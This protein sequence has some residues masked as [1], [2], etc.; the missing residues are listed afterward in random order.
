M[1]FKDHHLSKIFQFCDKD[2]YL[3]YALV[4]KQ[5]YNAYKRH[6]EGKC[7]TAIDSLATSSRCEYA[8]T[9]LSLCP[10]YHKK[11]SSLLTSIA[12][13]PFQRKSLFKFLELGFSVDTEVIKSVLIHEDNVELI[14]SLIVRGKLRLHNF[15]SSVCSTAA[16]FGRIHSLI[17][18]HSRRLPWDSMTTI[19][20]AK[21]GHF[22]CLRFAALAGC[23]LHSR[24]VEYAALNGHMFTINWLREVGCPATG[25]A[26][27]AAVQSG[28]ASIVRAVLL[29]GGPVHWD[30][31]KAAAA[32]GRIDMLILLRSSEYPWEALTISAAILSGHIET[33]K[34]LVNEGCPQGSNCMVAAASVGN[35]EMCKWLRSQGCPWDEEAMT[36]AAGGGHLHVVDWLC[37]ETAPVSSSAIIEAS[38][39]AHFTIAQKLI[40]HGVNMDGAAA[41]EAAVYSG[42]ERMVDIIIKTLPAEEDPVEEH[43]A[44][45]IT[46]VPPSQSAP[47]MQVVPVVSL[48]HDQQQQQQQ[49]QQNQPFTQSLKISQNNGILHTAANVSSR[50][51]SGCNQNE[52][53]V[54]G[55]VDLVERVKLKLSL[56]SSCSSKWETTNRENDH[57]NESHNQISSCM[58]GAD[59]PIMSNSAE[60]QST[61]NASYNN[62]TNGVLHLPVPPLSAS[63]R[64]IADKSRRSN[65]AV[66]MNSSDN[67]ACLNNK[68]GDEATKRDQNLQASNINHNSSSGRV[69][70]RITSTSSS[71]LLPANTLTSSQNQAASSLIKKANHH[72]NQQQSQ[73]ESQREIISDTYQ[74]SAHTSNNNLSRLLSATSSSVSN[75]SIENNGN[76]NHKTAS[77]GESFSSTIDDHHIEVAV[78]STSSMS[79]SEIDH[80]SSSFST[81][82]TTT[83]F[84][85]S[86]SYTPSLACTAALSDSTL[87]RKLSASHQIPLDATVMAALASRGLTDDFKWAASNSGIID[88]LSLIAAARTDQLHILKMI[89]QD[90]TFGNPLAATAEK[91]FVTQKNT[92]LPL[93]HRPEATY[94]LVAA[95]CGN[96]IATLR[97]L[98][99]IGC[100]LSP[101]VAAAAAQ[102]GDLGILKWLRDPQQMYFA[103]SGLVAELPIKA[104]IS[105]DLKP[106]VT[107]RGQNCS[108]EGL[109]GERSPVIPIAV[110]PLEFMTS[111]KRKYEGFC[112]DTSSFDKCAAV[113][114]LSN[115][116]EAPFDHTLDSQACSSSLYQTRHYRKNLKQMNIHDSVGTTVAGSV[117]L[118]DSSM[119]SSTHLLNGSISMS[120][121]VPIRQSI[122]ELD[123]QK[124]ITTNKDDNELFE[125]SPL[126]PTN[127]PDS[128]TPTASQFNSQFGNFSSLSSNN[129]LM[130]KLPPFPQMMMPS[131]NINHF[132]ISSPI[133]TTVVRNSEQDEHQQFPNKTLSS[134]IEHTQDVNQNSPMRHDK[135][136]FSSQT[137]KVSSSFSGTHSPI[138]QGSPIRQRRRSALLQTLQT[139]EE[140]SSPSDTT[141]LKYNEDGDQFS[142]ILNRFQKQQQKIIFAPS[143]SFQIAQNKTCVVGSPAQ[144]NCIPRVLRL[145]PLVL[146]GTSPDSC[147]NTTL[148]TAGK[149]TLTSSKTIFPYG[150]IQLPFPLH[151]VCPWDTRTAVSFV[152][153]GQISALLWL[154]N[155]NCPVDANLVRSAASKIGN[156]DIARRICATLGWSFRAEDGSVAHKLQ[157]DAFVSFLLQSGQVALDDMQNSIEAMEK[158]FEEQHMNN[159]QTG[160]NTL[161]SSYEGTDLFND[162]ADVDDEMGQDE[163]EFESSHHH[164][165]HL[166]VGNEWSLNSEDESQPIDERCSQ[167][168]PYSHYNNGGEVADYA[169]TG[170]ITDEEQDIKLNGFN[171]KYKIEKN[172]MN[173]AYFNSNRHSNLSAAHYS[174]SQDGIF[175]IL[176]E[177]VIEATSSVQHT[178]SS[179]S[180]LKDI[181]NVNHIANV[182]ISSPKKIEAA[183][184]NNNRLSPPS[185]SRYMTCRNATTSNNH[186][187]VSSPI[188]NSVSNPSGDGQSPESPLR[189]GSALVAVEGTNNMNKIPRKT[190]NYQLFDQDD[191]A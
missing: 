107:N 33:V 127:P 172:R 126:S 15:D 123:L 111:N 169:E 177:E 25:E 42:N 170:D 94:A 134:S 156:V 96:S 103:R 82:T 168:L 76:H 30:A 81:V 47:G 71:V 52:K 181:S 75:I 145:K 66:L 85:K 10:R 93:L 54:A 86:K 158:Q 32:A 43:R 135:S 139:A 79:H 90:Y 142:V 59:I 35:L 153:A 106:F 122:N 137:E 64:R 187:L 151:A 129:N 128:C 2:E 7:V 150:G 38:K 175:D 179:S 58:V 131:A 146:N 20:A 154:V 174:P 176:T 53:I 13:N 98:V 143:T 6:T 44:S 83:P 182:N 49:Q 56:S 45:R 144:L 28:R 12:R 48:N 102:K 180:S 41:L 74:N 114:D 105:A 1:I 133:L 100:P 108:S 138:L 163:D 130:T 4:N 36:A 78:A 67:A 77:H 95:I 55:A 46:P 51:S 62:L 148:K 152:Q 17:F 157:R 171:S 115:S 104:A 31:C 5:W 73:K 40:D 8:S 26:T 160:E 9:I 99:S 27:V 161:L 125:R 110:K 191:E 88:C 164:Q 91:F 80:H 3:F 167:F 116:T 188:C 185:S 120:F 155:S 68:L 119:F 89:H 178:F 166:G 186:N 141:S 117:M 50:S 159:Q 11:S 63:S 162:G 18:F 147:K 87:L 84:V 121:G 29:F 61:F 101:A 189:A 97:W 183:K 149:T 70:R 39:C 34:W 140:A 132:Q 16:F 118:S 165:Q 190:R 124:N 69:I 173:D 72:I 57:I 109:S 112:N 22:D 19:N 14:D 184:N 65:A 136:S 92:H 24:C 23:P 21:S 60:C 37:T 113:S